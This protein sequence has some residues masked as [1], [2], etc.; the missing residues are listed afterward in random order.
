[1]EGGRAVDEAAKPVSEQ[2]SIEQLRA[3]FENGSPTVVCDTLLPFLRLESRSNGDMRVINDISEGISKLLYPWFQNSESMRGDDQR[4]LYTLLRPDGLL[5]DT[6]LQYHILQRE[7]GTAPLGSAPLASFPG[8]SQPMG[9][10]LSIGVDLLPVE[11]HS[12]AGLDM[13]GGMS[14]PADFVKRAIVNTDQGKRRTAGFSASALEYLLYHLCKAL[15]PPRENATDQTRNLAAY[16][17][18]PSSSVAS[19]A[20]HGSIVPGSVAHSIAREYICFFL[21]VVVPEAPRAP[22]GESAAERSPIKQIRDRLHDLSPKKPPAGSMAGEHI[23]YT[24]ARKP[25]AVETDLLDICTYGASLEL[26]SYFS[27]CAVLLWL[28]AVPLDI[29]TSI[30]TSIRATL[31]S[32]PSQAKSS[33]HGGFGHS[34][35]RQDTRPAQAKS[36]EASS[37]VWIPS[38]S[39]ISA[40]DLFHLI[41][42]YI[43][44]GE[45]QMERFHLTNSI[46]VGRNG[47]SQAGGSREYESIEK[48]ISMN[49]DTLA[50]VL[51]SCGRTSSAD[52]DIWI[53]FLDITASIWIR[54][55]M[56]WRGSKIDMPGTDGS[57]LL[58]SPSSSD[59]SP[60]W[61]SRILLIVRGLSPVLYGQTLALF[62][63]Q[64]ASN[65]IDL[66]AH[67]A[68]ATGNRQEY[69][70]TSGAAGRHSPAV[71]LG[72]ARGHTVQ[73]WI[74]GTVS[75]V[76]GHLHNIDALSVV[77]RVVS[78]FASTELRAILA[79]IE[80]CQL[81]AFPALRSRSAEDRSKPDIT[82]STGIAADAEM[83]T[84]T[85]APH[86]KSLGRDTFSGDVKEDVFFERLVGSA[87]HQLVSFAQDIVAFR[88]GSALLDSVIVG[89]L[90][91]PPVCTVFSKPPGASLRAVIGALHSAELLAERQLR[92]IVPE[93]SSDQA[94]SLVSDIFLVLSRIFSASD[95]DGSAPGGWASGASGTGGRSETM[96][97]RAQSLQ[98]AQRRISALYVR[99]AAVFYT[100]RRE[101]ESIK[102]SIDDSMLS[103]AAAAAAS[104][105][106]ATSNRPAVLAGSSRGSGDLG[107]DE[108]GSSCVFAPDMAH[109][110]LTPRGRWELKTG[111]KKFTTQ[112]LLA[113][114]Q[115]TSASSGRGEQVLAPPE[116]GL[117]S[118]IQPMSSPLVG[119]PSGRASADGRLPA[120]AVDAALLPRGPLAQLRA[121]SYENQWLLDRVLPFNELVNERYQQ[122]LDLLEASAYPVPACMRS[123]KLNFRFIAAYQN[124]RFF[125]LLLSTQFDA[126]GG[127]EV[128]KLVEV[129]RPQ[130]KA[131][132]IIVR[133]RF[134]GVNFIDTYYR[135]GVYKADLPSSLGQEGAGEVVEIGAGVEGFA[136]GDYVAYLGARDTYAQYTAAPASRA[137]KLDASLIPLDIAAAGLLQGLTAHTLA[138]RSYAVKEGDWVLVQAG[139]GGTGRLLTQLC[140]HFGATVIATVS[141]EEK[142][143][144]A[145]KA[146]ADHVIFYTH[147]NVPE[148]VKEIVPEGVHVVFDGV[149]KATFQGS[150]QSLRRLGSMVSFGNA[151]GT[152]P[153]VDILQ[154]AGGNITL[155]RPVLYGYLVTDE[156]FNRHLSEV[157]EL[158]GQKKLDIQIFK[159]YD[160]ADA[161]QAHADLQGRKTTGKLLLRV[162]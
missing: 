135:S 144:V 60:V 76:F 68:L 130:A 120:S 119:T 46:P 27:A 148:K 29:R 96:R 78:A 91:N 132:Q 84:P 15:V 47:R 28:P 143:R 58:S 36:A 149:G 49:A 108:Q 53:P 122:L 106:G 22:H 116:W 20:R 125:A 56:P 8:Y 6:L 25:G 102:Q 155:Q 19:A 23:E 42:A 160:L 7:R 61:Q 126:I 162:D 16:P 127:P 104:P 118:R 142:A 51:A 44:K 63:K 2:L 86:S 77:E 136:V 13:N 21:P 133:N 70:G 73:S 66:L 80:R 40:L 33:G 88:S 79:A 14:L 75:S 131:G 32:R 83:R 52:T 74:Q 35:V 101:I 134:A 85:H 97:A 37:W 59:L 67:T 1:M 111:R 150:I 138:T 99:L 12:G 39:H 26:A 140:K 3:A 17:S 5:V 158:I 137:V 65:H 41:V 69:M 64:I 129:S 62:L 82:G 30:R 103:A 151:S 98:D 93:R 24:S 87:Q 4:S 121:R 71:H 9:A 18:R 109:G 38:A 94:R 117:R 81:E 113:S 145:R 92:L 105:A 55:I 161:A 34:N 107:E 110:S 95:A 112:S 153:P 43:A 114:P 45:R 123:F 54:Y 72:G 89:A 146:G 90:G 154:L 147:E 139:A 128:L 156:E 48:R 57:T 115:R 157:F 124:I 31:G 152:V 50:M 159:T 100:S 11:Y 10:G 141:T